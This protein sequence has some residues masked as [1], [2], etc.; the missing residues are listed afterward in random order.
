MEA[1]RDAL[2][3]NGLLLVNVVARSKVQRENAENRIR[4]VLLLYYSC[5]VM[6]SIFINRLPLPPLQVFPRLSSIDV[7]ED[8]NRVLIGHRSERDRSGN[9]LK[10]LISANGHWSQMSAFDRYRDSLR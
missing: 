8:L 3:E 6:L 2:D 1:A 4:K 10:G 5:I 7:D 9:A